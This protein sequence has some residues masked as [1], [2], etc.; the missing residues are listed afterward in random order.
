MLTLRGTP[1]LYN[2]E[3]IGMSD[4]YLP[5]I[6]L[7][8]DP[9]AIWFYHQEI[10][11]G[12]PPEVVLAR[13]A[14]DSRDRCRTPLQWA[15]TPN[16]SFSPEGV[17]TWLPVNPNYAQGVNVA[18]QQDDPKSML[19][20]YKQMLRIR[21]ENP[22]LMVGDYT[23]LHESSS[24]YFAFLRQ[25][26]SPQQTCLVVINFFDQPQQVDFEL[27]TNALQCVIS[28]N[29]SVNE[30]LSPNSLKIAPFE[31]LITKPISN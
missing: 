24:E 31:I 21:R 18:E 15:N 19:N 7:F 27:P 17:R 10:A 22:A 29:R 14:L 6:S 28:T 26:T 20:F 11:N 12:T 8:G 9:P 5:D 3:E 25:S 1:F 2:G 30:L 16:A 23:A 4:Y 13:A